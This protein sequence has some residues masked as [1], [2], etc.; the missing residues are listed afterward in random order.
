M[1][2]VTVFVFSFEGTIS[3]DPHG[4]GERFPSSNGERSAGKVRDDF[5]TR[6]PWK[7]KKTSW[8]YKIIMDIICGQ[9]RKNIHLTMTII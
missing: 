8:Y 7:E 9:K 2:G 6:L 4:V 3:L 1:V 5:A